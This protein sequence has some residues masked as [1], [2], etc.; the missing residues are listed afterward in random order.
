M[1]AIAQIITSVATLLVAIGSLLA[2]LKALGLVHEVK[3]AT[4]GMAKRLEDAA[5]AKGNLQGRLAEK[6]E[7]LEDKSK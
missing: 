2:T 5:E 4:N 1:N 7:H 3:N 6:A